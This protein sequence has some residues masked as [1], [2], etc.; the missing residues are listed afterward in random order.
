MDSKDT[1]LKQGFSTKFIYRF[2]GGAALGAF[3]ASIPIS[4]GQSTELDFVQIGLV[5]L[6]IISSGLLSSIWSKKFIEAMTRVL[7]SFA[8]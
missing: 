7:E 5:S 3:L 8:P 2:L 1:D 6:L 4:Y